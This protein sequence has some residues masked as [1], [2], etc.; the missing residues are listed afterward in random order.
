MEKVDPNQL[1]RHL[2]AVD[3]ESYRS[4]LLPSNW[5]QPEFYW[6]SKNMDFEQWHHTNG[7]EVLWLSGPAECHISDASS[8]IVDLMKE[9]PSQSQ[10]LVLYFF[11][12]TASSED[13]IAIT[14]VSTII[15]QLACRLPRLKGEFSTVFLRTLLDAILRGEPLSNMKR[16]RFKTNDSV[17]ETVEKILE[18]V[19]SRYW[20]ALRAVMGIERGIELSLIIDGLDKIEYQKYEFIR[21]LRVFT[22]DLRERPSTTR[23][24]LTSRPQAEIKQILDQL[25][26]IEYDRERKG[27]NFLIS[28]SRNKR[29]S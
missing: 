27:S 12:S 7:S 17:E 11:C 2:P 3:Q 6:I 10:H 14:F 1:L 29:G 16:S 24:L 19:S 25:P 23:V 5:D 28:Y 13:P 20:G 8:C 9:K 18:P 21:E 4:R 22:E 15:H 26:S